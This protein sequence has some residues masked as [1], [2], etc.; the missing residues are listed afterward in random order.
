MAGTKSE[1]P[2]F[3]AL[4]PEFPFEINESKKSAP[5]PQKPLDPARQLSQS[6]RHGVPLATAS[7]APRPPK[8]SGSATHR[9]RTEK[10]SMS[11]RPSEYSESYG[12]ELIELMAEGLS[13]TAAAAELGFHRDTIYDWAEKYPIF[14]DALK[15]AR[16]K[17]VLKL[18]RDLLGAA[19]GPTVTSRIFALKNADPGEW[20][21]KHE[22][23]HGV[24][25]ELST[26]LSSLDGLTRGIP[27]GKTS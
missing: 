14:S 4:K 10:P 9:S 13:I 21:D 22:V 5:A 3:L 18:E 24:T 16:G 27:A 19:D 11:G 26:L 6:H 17:R 8:G 12:N 7:P 1:N 2:E 23:S 20:R 15:R 25:P